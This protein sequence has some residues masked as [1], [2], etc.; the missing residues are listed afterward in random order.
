MKKY[1]IVDEHGREM[2]AELTEGCLKVTMTFYPEESLT[3]EEV[4][5]SMA[6]TITDTKEYPKLEAIPLVTMTP[7]GKD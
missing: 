4:C 6:W 5:E 2:V 1:D 3:M 7:F